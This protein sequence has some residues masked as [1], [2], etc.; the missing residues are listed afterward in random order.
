MAKQELNGLIWSGIGSSIR[1]NWKSRRLNLQSRPESD[2]RNFDHQDT[3]LDI[4]RRC[5]GD[6]LNPKDFIVNGRLGP[7]D[8]LLRDPLK[9]YYQLYCN[10][11]QRM[12]HLAQ[13]MKLLF[14]ISNANNELYS[15]RFLAYVGNEVVREWPWKDFPFTSVEAQR[16][17]SQV[18]PYTVTGLYDFEVQNEQ[19]RAILR[20]LHYE[21]WTPISFFR[22]IFVNH[23]VLSVQDFFEILICNYR[24]VRITKE[25]NKRLT[26]MGFGQCRP[27]YAYDAAGI[28]IYEARM[29]IATF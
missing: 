16:I 26:E 25:E 19:I 18:T 20:K 9:S 21:H 23:G 4:I 11:L 12:W 29:W 1:G 13:S 8:V 6:S 17:I 5:S 14:D 15:D 24:V 22:D 3:N 10:V 27:V 7:P 2:K 28:S